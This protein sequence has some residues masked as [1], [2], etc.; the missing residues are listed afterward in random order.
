[1]RRGCLPH[2]MKHAKRRQTYLLYN[3]ISG[4]VIFFFF[5]LNIVATLVALP[6]GYRNAFSTAC[7]RAPREIALPAQRLQNFWI[8]V[9]IPSARRENILSNSCPGVLWRRLS[10]CSV[11]KADKKNRAVAFS[12]WYYG[13][14]GKGKHKWH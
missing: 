1:M 5:I 12:I 13:T 2:K 4:A 14:M 3:M 9:A 11:K 10:S 7:L 6:P 8:R